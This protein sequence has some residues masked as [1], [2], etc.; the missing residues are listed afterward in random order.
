MTR[1][2]YRRSCRTCCTTPPATR[3]LAW[4]LGSKL[5]LAALAHQNIIHVYDFVERAK[6]KYIV[7][8]YIEGMSLDHLMVAYL[9][10]SELIPH[11]DVIII[12]WAMA[13]ARPGTEP[14]SA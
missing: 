14:A 1:R 2:G 7:M 11:D 3:R 9:R 12:G 10:E 4:V 5:S 8:E 6:S 13:A